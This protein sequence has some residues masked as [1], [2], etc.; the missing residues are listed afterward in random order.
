MNKILV[1]VVLFL[2]GSASVQA[3]LLDRGG[4]LIYDSV[5]NVTWLQDGNFAATQDY[6]TPTGRRLR[7]SETLGFA[8]GRMTWNE[9][10][11]WVAT[12]SYHDSFR[13]V[14]WTDWRLPSVGPIVHTGSP[15]FLF[16]QP[17]KTPQSEL[18]TLL[19]ELVRGQ[20]G[21]VL[22]FFFNVMATQQW[23]GTEYVFE[24]IDGIYPNM[25]EGYAWWMPFDQLASGYHSIAQK[26][27]NLYY[28][29]AVRD[30]DVAIV[31]L[32]GTL[33]FIAPALAGLGMR[34][35]QIS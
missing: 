6:V 17:S 22:P 29:W 10:V 11:T 2:A 19:S 15:F 8:P 21:A 23:T 27:N 26:N 12:L 34:R 25:A 13:D 5:L 4:G 14:D 20:G 24:P 7:D 1:S 16:D 33:W 28:S 35:R 30:G 9:A 31:P 3:A 32:P 18:G